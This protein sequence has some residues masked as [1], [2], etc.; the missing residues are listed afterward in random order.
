MAKENNTKKF[1]NINKWFFMSKFILI[2]VVGGFI[3]YSIISVNLNSKITT[4]TENSV[5]VYGQRQSRNIANSMAQMI[6][7]EINDSVSWRITSPEEKSLFG[8]TATYRIIDTVV[9]G[10]TL[11]KVAVTGN[12]NNNVTNVMA[13]VEKPSTGFVP[14]IV[15]G[16]WTANG[17]LDNTISDMY[18]DGRDHDLNRNYVPY[19]GVYGISTSVEFYNTQKAEI[20]GTK[21]SIDYPMSYPENPNVIEEN[22]NWGGEFPTTPDAV[23]GIP[24]G[25]LKSIAQSGQDGSQYVTDPEDLNLPLSGITYVE[26]NDDDDNDDDDNDDDND[27]DDD[28]IDMKKTQS[29]GILVCHNSSG[30]TRIKQIKL[31]N[32]PFKGLIIG[33]Y[34]FH[35]HLDVH[36]A[37]ILLSQN[38]ETKK[39]CSGNKDHEVLYSSEIIKNATSILGIQ[40]NFSGGTNYGFQ[41]QRLTVR[42]WLE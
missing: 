8:G 17:P 6:I 25:T 1:I 15:H 37:I 41:K 42:H 11:I 20:G 36:G 12:Y 32:Y 4:G 13:L 23:L 34:M 26:I 30:T 27:D 24:E 7:S 5:K 14:P 40:S 16:A 9:A 31:K 35:F 2:I 33:D 28:K 29:K 19:T 10:D 22:Y 18:I 39:K 3:S 21:D 38:L